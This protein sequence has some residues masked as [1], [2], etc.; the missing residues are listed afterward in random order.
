[1]NTSVTPLKIPDVS[2]HRKR[3]KT[4]FIESLLVSG[5]SALPDLELLELLLFLSHPRGDVKP[6]AK[7]LLK[8]FKSFRGV[9]QAPREKL[10]KVDGIGDSTISILKIVQASSTRLAWQEMAQRP[11]F[12]HWK[13]VVDYCA[14]TMGHL[15]VEQFRVLFL[16][17][18]NMLIRDEVMPTGT[19]NQTAVFPREVIKRT[20]DLNAANIILAHNHPSGNTTPSQADFDITGQIEAAARP[21]DIMVLDHI[22]IG[23]SG[24]YSFKE[25]HKI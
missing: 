20:L 17:T 24:Y 2:G 12:E 8:E 21:M 16:N 19:I 3:L 6:K 10:E 7:N 18:Q 5:E 9:I 23:A 22:I 13:N 1:M 11:V 15:D 25:N 14:T 4:R